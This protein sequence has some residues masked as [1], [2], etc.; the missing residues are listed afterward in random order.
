MKPG[1]SLAAFFL[2]TAGNAT[3]QSPAQPDVPPQP[4]VI[5][6]VPAVPGAAANLSFAIA[7][8]VVD[9]ATGNPIPRAE[10][11]LRIKNDEAVVSADAGGK[12]LFDHL[13][14]GKYQL[15]ARAPGYSSQGLNQHGSYFS[16]VVVGNGLDSRHIVFRLHP[17][18]VVYG[19][20][21][22][23]RG[24]AVR[25]AS[26]WILSPAKNTSQPAL[27]AQ[28]QTNDLGEYRLAGL[29]PGRY[30]VAVSARPWYAQTGFRYAP[31]QSE[32]A[33]ARFGGLSRVPA[34][35]LDSALD[36]VYPVTFYPGVTDQPS[37]T[38]LNLHEGETQQADIPLRAVPSI[39]LR[40]TNLP[41][42]QSASPRI[43]VTQRLFAVAN[44]GV[45]MDVA[46]IVPGE[47]EIAGL[48]PGDLTLSLIQHDGERPNAEQLEVNVSG[49]ATVDA[50]K[51]LPSAS[52]SGHVILPQGSGAI[53]DAG[54]VILRENNRA[55][56]ARLKK[57]G[58]FSFPAL[59][60]GSYDIFVNLP[61][62]P[63][64]VQKVTASGAKT[65]GR[66]LI[67]TGAEEVQLTIVLGLGVGEITGI[68][69]LEGRPADGVMVLLLPESA[70]DLD[71]DLRM[72]Q[73][74]SDGSFGLGNIT[75]GKYHLLAIQ[76]GWDLDYRDP[77]VLKPYLAK[78]QFLQIAPNDVKK[79]TV[80]VQL[81]A[82]PSAPPL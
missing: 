11:T 66:H 75:P 56:F 48:P 4:S 30:L 10:L 21:T 51:T 67:I 37:A 32:D 59:P 17:Q 82:R 50:S 2:L 34:A 35:Q 71:S 79:L 19:R 81:A 1:I 23:E 43:A 76:N 38:E 53:G 9:A 5:Q 77:A 40:V 42:D 29:L 6:S 24:E 69:M 18:A 70:E 8:V 65:S 55:R 52:A 12:F 45:A 31:G 64:Y 68:A 41:P 60:P 22:D 46:Q 73:S 80:D 72:D 7:G 26:V 54:G 62:L 49:E 28:S 58:T 74:D 63:E 16:G 27:A 47:V 15:F 57:D 25:N 44:F 20:V 13:E 39:H 61:G 36:V 78:A 33:R 3:A 14:P